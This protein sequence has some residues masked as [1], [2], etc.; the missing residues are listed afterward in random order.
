MTEEQGEREQANGG[1]GASI[2]LSIIIVNWNTRELLADCLTSV[3]DSKSKVAGLPIQPSTFN[4]QPVTVETFVVDNASADGSAAM[5]RERYPWVHLILNTENI[6]FARANNQAIAASHGRYV[7]LLNSDA[8]LAPDA[9]AAMLCH[10]ETDPRAGIAGVCQV[11]PDGRQ[12]FCYGRF[13][14]L[15]REARTLFGLHRWDL[16]PFDDLHQPRPVDWVSGACLMARRAMLNQIGLL[17][18][19]FF[20]FGEEVDLCLRAVRAGWKVILVPS[21]P[22][23]HAHA[24][25]TGKTP[26]RILRL[27]RG[28]LHYAR[29]HWPFLNVTLLLTMIR[30]SALAKLSVFG[31]LALGNPNLI[32]KRRLWHK[33]V[34]QVCRTGFTS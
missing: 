30:I 13:P 11:Y 20:M 24:G 17:D 31:L 9:V 12:Q 34:T 2:D 27:Y 1:S 26:E 23:V 25:S 10:L 21:T 22:I 28:K 18:E 33:V 29:K 15:W 4:L 19:S 16:T 7:L 5:V 32:D 8:Q 6:G 3:A 14:T